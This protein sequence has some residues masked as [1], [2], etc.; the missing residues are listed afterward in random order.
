[1]GYFLRYL[2]T[3]NAELDLTTLEKLLQNDDPRYI[4]LQDEID[5]SGQ[6]K[7]GDQFIGILEIN[8]RH[9]EL[10]DDEINELR[11]LVM[12][13]KSDRREAVL[14]VLNSTTKLVA[15]ELIWQGDNPDPTLELADPLWD[16]LFG[17]YSG[18]LQAD[19]EGFYDSDGLILEMSLKI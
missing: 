14:N 3:Q 12:Y 4:I 9:D 1:L 5:G 15:L 18:L 17:T 7:Y 19:N 16:V 2:I 8:H 11:E 10:F 6:F 13:S